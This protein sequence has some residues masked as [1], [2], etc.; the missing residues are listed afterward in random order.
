MNELF[1]NNV[2]FLFQLNGIP[3]KIIFFDENQKNYMR[4]RFQEFNLPTTKQC[5]LWGQE[6]NLTGTQVRNSEKKRFKI[7]LIITGLQFH[8]KRKRVQ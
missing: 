5:E 8:Q 6:I 7:Q 4:A 3:P 2:M 1:K